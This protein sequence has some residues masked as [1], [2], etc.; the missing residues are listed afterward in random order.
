MHWG[1]IC[2]RIAD[3]NEYWDEALS[4]LTMSGAIEADRCTGVPVAVATWCQVGALARI[5]VLMMTREA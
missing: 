2:A 1:T 4:M 3:A 5:E